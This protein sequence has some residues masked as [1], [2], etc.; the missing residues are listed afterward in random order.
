MVYLSV[1]LLCYRITCLWFC[2]KRVP[3]P[4]YVYV[5]AYILCIFE[6]ERIVVL[7][8]DLSLIYLLHAVSLCVCVHVCTASIK[9]WLEKSW[10]DH[11]RP[12]WV[13]SYQ[14]RSWW[15]CLWGVEYKKNPDPRLQCGS[16]RVE[17]AHYPRGRAKECL[18]TGQWRRNH[19][20]QLLPSVGAP[21]P[22]GSALYLRVPVSSSPALPHPSPQPTS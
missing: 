8:L 9:Y 12:A 19:Q 10:E 4:V 5:C 14:K 22:H 20:P 21:C 6:F 16:S 13:F 17:E 7:R 15:P 3:D 11:G 18:G 2:N 1:I